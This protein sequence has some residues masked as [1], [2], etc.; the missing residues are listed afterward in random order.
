MITGAER[1]P[2]DLWP[3]FAR[4]LVRG[5]MNFGKA[6]VSRNWFAVLTLDMIRNVSFRFTG[7]VMDV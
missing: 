7:N 4:Q 3:G 5:K 2:G 6:Q 1:G